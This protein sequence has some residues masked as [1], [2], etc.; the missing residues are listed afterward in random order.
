M[1]KR[2][3]L[4]GATGFIG[5]HILKNINLKKTDV[6]LLVRPETSQQRLGKLPD[7]VEK[8]FVNLGDI[9][10]LRRE[11]ADREFDV[12]IHV[13][14]IRNRKNTS[15][16][17]Y[18]LA[19]V[20]ATEQLALKAMENSAKFIFFS[21]VGVYGSVPGHLPGNSSTPFVGDNSYHSSKIRCEAMIDRYV[22]YGLNSVIIRPAITYG[23]GDFGFPY[24]LIKMIDK[25]R[26]LLADP[27]PTIHLANVT[28]LVDAVKKL[29]E[30]DYKPGSVYNIADRNPVNL[31]ELADYIN[32][33]LKNKAFSRRLIINSMFFALAAKICKVLKLH[34]WE[35]RFT[36]FSK[37]W[38]YDVEGAYS[39]IN[40]RHSE[41]IPSI[42]S[43]VEWYQKIN[44]KQK[45]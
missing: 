15:E 37:S 17:D 19:N 7:R 18:H 45:T 39:E 32:Q 26:I 43:V 4:T 16:E 23:T 28:L 38:Y 35:S 11:L 36:L 8:I 29:I 42:R 13:A 40:L 12:I 44:G 5:R 24:Q 3:L 6:T 25:K 41:T 9:K 1:N 34:S 22:L 33:E 2:I 14:A 27:A 21:S 20:A 10:R 31:L 30:M